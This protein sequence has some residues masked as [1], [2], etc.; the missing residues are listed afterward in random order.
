MHVSEGICRR[1]PTRGR[2]SMMRRMRRVQGMVTLRMKMRRRRR[3]RRGRGRGRS[4]SRGRGRGRRRS[5]G[6]SGLEVMG[7]V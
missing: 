4:K 1:K 6:R 7:G 5:R 3:R 2:A